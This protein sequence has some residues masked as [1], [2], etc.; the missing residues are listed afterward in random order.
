M[1]ESIITRTDDLQNRSYNKNIITFT[2]FLTPSEQ[3]LVLSRNYKNIELN[4][5]GTFTE[6]KRAFFL[7]DYVDDFKVEDY[8][9]ALKVVYSFKELSHRD[10]LGSLMGLN[11]KRQCIGDIYVSEKEAYIY[12]VKEMADFIKHNLTKVGSVGVKALEVNLGEVEIPEL[13]TEKI[14]F[15][16]NSIRLDSVVAHSFKISRDDAVRMIKEG[17]VMLDYIECL[18]PSKELKE[19]ATLSLRGHGKV[20]LLKIGDK[21][22][23]GS[24]FVEVEKYL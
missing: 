16:V 11:I 7:P 6:R 3:S 20:R 10:F 2:N 17:V 8:I 22:Q 14:K 9:V 4:G 18:V 19:G 24:T 23:K 21:S 1:E 13:K 12:V 15:T 5:G